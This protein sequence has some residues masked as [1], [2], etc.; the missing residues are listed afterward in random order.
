MRRLILGSEHSHSELCGCCQIQ[1]KNAG[2]TILVTVIISQPLSYK[3]TL[4]NILKST[5][6]EIVF[7]NF[8]NSQDKNSTQTLT[9]VRIKII[10]M[11]SEF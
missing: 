10:K 11:M 5:S 2:Y 7:K 9:F 4:R 1:N 8:F 6:Y 3:D